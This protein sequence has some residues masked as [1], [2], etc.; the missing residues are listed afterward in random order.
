MGVF[1][2]FHF[3]FYNILITQHA[4]NNFYYSI[5][6]CKTV[7]EKK[8]DFPKGGFKYNGKMYDYCPKHNGKHWCPTE[9][10]KGTKQMKKGHW[11]W[12]NNNCPTDATILQGTQSGK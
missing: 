3:V 4:I 8:C 5:G 2:Y 9:V 12:C 10:D 1:R 11:G 7:D 6:A